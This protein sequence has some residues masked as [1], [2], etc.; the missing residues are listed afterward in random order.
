MV[1]GGM[2]L[3]EL[4]SGVVVPFKRRDRDLLF[5]PCPAC[6][7]TSSFLTR[8]TSTLSTSIRI[9]LS[10][11]QKGENY[12]KNP[13]NPECRRLPFPARP[14]FHSSTAYHRRF[15]F[16]FSPTLLTLAL[17]PHA[18]AH[19]HLHRASPRPSIAVH[20][21]HHHHHHS[22]S[23]LYLHYNT[24]LHHTTLRLRLQPLHILLP[25]SFPHSFASS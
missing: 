6:T 23:F 24:P 22:H 18:H 12:S 9:R 15:Y 11:S 17:S 14:L 3:S 7:S 20:S 2:A 1:Y 25:L 16:H 8:R 19:A 5:L 4:R 10:P 21:K 13:P